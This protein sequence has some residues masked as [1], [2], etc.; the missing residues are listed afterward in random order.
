MLNE[1]GKLDESI[2]PALAIT[3]PH[4]VDNEEEMLALE[5]KRVM[6]QLEQTELEA[7]S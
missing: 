3:E 1:S 4:V 6:S 2:L 7:L 5:A